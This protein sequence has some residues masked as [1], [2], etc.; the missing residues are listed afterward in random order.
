MLI[1]GKETEEKRR[2]STAYIPYSFYD[3]RLPTYFASVPLHW[4]SEFELDYVVAGAGEFTCGGEKLLAGPG[5][6]MLLPPSMLH[7]A[8]PRG[9]A[10]LNYY[11]L[12]FSPAFLGAGLGDRCSVELLRPLAEGTRQLRCCTASGS[13]GYPALGQTAERIFACAR[14]QLPLPELLLKSELL[15]LLWLLAS[16]QESARPHTVREGGE[17]AVRAALE[18]MQRHYQEPVH[19]A[20]L[21][22]TVHL[23]ESY[24][25]ASFKRAAGVSAM[26]YLAQLRANAACEALT[27]TARPV[28]EIASAVG[29]GNLSN[30]NRQFKKIVGCTPMEYRR[31]VAWERLEQER[32]RI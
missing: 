31:K 18:Y 6:L 23:S 30:F 7:A 28:A 4:H 26:E 12:V 32:D 9:E 14:G 20:Q 1:P 2:H 24:F 8:Y 21:A 10:G 25:M 16:D 11:A 19:I 27:G 5:D 17:A 29:F 15:R 13:T 3:C 22:Q